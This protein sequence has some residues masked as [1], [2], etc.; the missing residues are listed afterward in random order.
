VVLSP[1]A[2]LHR[3][4]TYPAPCSSDVKVCLGNPASS[5]SQKNFSAFNSARNRSPTLRPRF[6]SGVAVHLEIVVV[7]PELFPSLLDDL[8]GLTQNTL[9]HGGISENYKLVGE[10]SGV[11]GRRGRTPSTAPQG[12]HRRLGFVRRICPRAG[13]GGLGHVLDERVHR[14]DAWG[15]RHSFI[16]NFELFVVRV[17]RGCPTIKIALFVVAKTPAASQYLGEFT[18]D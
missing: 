5:C 3:Q 12:G 2:L 18:Q 4:A 13:D 10:G 11:R 9:V 7:G 15:R 8:N 14:R 17:G 16:P 1:L 6:S